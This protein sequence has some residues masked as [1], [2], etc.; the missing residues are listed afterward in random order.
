MPQCRFCLEDADED[1]LIAPC[2]CDG[3]HKF[4]HQECLA[5]WRR[6][7]FP[8]ARR[9]CNV[10]NAKW[11]TK[12]PP[13]AEREFFAR[14]VKTAPRYRPAARDV[15]HAAA[16]RALLQSA[17]GLIAQAPRRAE[18]E[19]EALQGDD[20]ILT[21][22]TDANAA[23]ARAREAAEAPAPA[24]APTMREPGGFAYQS[25]VRKKCERAKMPGHFCDQCQGFIDATKDQL[26]DADV[27]KLQD[28]CSR[29][30]AY[31]PPPGTPEGFWELSFM[32]SQEKRKQDSLDAF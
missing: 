20:A 18:A 8:G 31:H 26:S 27:K 25:V 32:D 24:P 23:A 5:E 7:R 21:W 9:R 28:E 13:R 16:L 3:S 4:V 22:A 1:Q 29:H 19:A 10:C 30:K 17:G 15:A 12:P 11:T 2:N 14:A 6:G